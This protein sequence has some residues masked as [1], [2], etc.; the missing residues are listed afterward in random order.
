M[1]CRV[2]PAL[3]TL[4]VSAQIGRPAFQEYCVVLEVRCSSWAD[5]RGLRDRPLIRCVAFFF[6]LLGLEEYRQRGCCFWEGEENSIRRGR[7]DG[8]RP[9]ERGV[10]L[11]GTAALAIY[12]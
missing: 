4:A 12:P 10:D 1:V 7:H 3:Q 9:V 8:V 6:R 2:P 11:T 5:D